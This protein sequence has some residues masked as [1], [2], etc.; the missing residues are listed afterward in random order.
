ML[1]ITNGA[2]IEV[3]RAP[4]HPP[5]QR[6][7]PRMLPLV[8]QGQHERDDCLLI[9]RPSAGPSYNASAPVE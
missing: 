4:V 8:K 5:Q 3:R 7:I 9:V 2:S 6:T 1:R